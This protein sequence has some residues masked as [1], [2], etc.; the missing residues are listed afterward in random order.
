MSQAESRR[1]QAHCPLL[2]AVR[3]QELALA[4][5]EDGQARSLHIPLPVVEQSSCG[6]R[7]SLQAQAA[8]DAL[9][10]LSQ[11]QGL[12]ARATLHVV[13]EPPWLLHMTVPWSAQLLSSAQADA[14]VNRC[15]IEAGWDLGR[16]QLHVDDAPYGQP[17]LAIAYPLGWIEALRA[18]A[19]AQGWLPGRMTGLSVLAWREAR[20]QT[21]AVRQ[22]VLAGERDTLFLAGPNHLESVHAVSALRAPPREEDLLKQ[23]QRLRWRQPSWTDGDTRL[24]GLLAG[25]QAEPPVARERLDWLPAAPGEG[26]AVFRWLRAGLQ[27]R[28]ALDARSPAPRGALLHGLALA[29]VLSLGLVML[30]AA[31]R[32]HGKESVLAGQTAQMGLR[33]DAQPQ[34]QKQDPKAAEALAAVRR[35][36]RAP[37]SDLLAVLLPPRDIDVA[38]L[39]LE[40]GHSFAAPGA[41]KVKLQLEGR[42][43]LDMTRYM[44]YLDHR[45]PLGAVVLTQHALRQDKAEERYR[46]TL[47]LTWQR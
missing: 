19:Q 2:L 11:A 45:G 10:A 16:W 1:R 26:P 3:R 14:Y 47:E 5:S 13:F 28:S 43:A 39:D 20:R 38:L 25:A 29:A 12:P 7:P 32:L 4:W 24:H 8:R 33:S 23:W 22:L 35:Q 40:F 31:H 37:Y 42:T 41:R 46:F 15:A 6:D 30:L 27:E 21:G 9:Q 34:L 18:S 44:A 36:L 17:R